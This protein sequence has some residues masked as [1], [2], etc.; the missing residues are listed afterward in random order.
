MKSF[1]K[2][3][4]LSVIGV[5]VFA[6]ALAFTLISTNI[7]RRMNEV[8]AQQLHV[9]SAEAD[10][11]HKTL[12]VA[13]LHADSLL[14]G[15]DLVHESRDGHVD[16]PRMRRGNVA[17]EA[18]T[19]VTKSPKGQNIQSNA[20]DASDRV[21]L[22]AMLNR[23]PLRSWSSL[24][25]RALYQAERLHH[26]EKQD[27]N[28]RIVKTVDDLDRLLQDR[29]ENPDL[30][31]GFLGIEGL[32]CLEGDFDNVGVMI[33][34]GFRMMSATHFFD[35]ELGGSAHGES[36]EGLSEFGRKVIEHLQDNSILV[37]LAHVSPAMID[38]I[39]EIATAP[40]VV[41]HTGVKGTCDS[42]RNLSDEHLKG[43]AKNGGVIAIGMW[44]EAVCGTD[45]HAS[46]D[47]MRYVTNL[48]GIDHVAIGSDYDGS[49][50]AP[51]DI[52]G[53][54]LITEALMEDGFTEEE[55]GKIMG[56]NI[57]RVLRETLPK[58]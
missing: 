34:A 15:R 52:T 56:G 22:L 17:L 45:I 50:T 38:D 26:F 46:V 58:K 57:V 28:F 27:D 19:V 40:V 47:A 43:I 8:R 25:E 35:N 33:D 11:L 23:W 49:I 21:T 54:P 44:E 6:V 51:F 12:I 14:F 16:F 36:H 31:G 55:I 39:L 41:S 5:T 9:A 37:D 3:H 2:R 18:F 13:D 29:E 53:F 24:K 30:I 20:A 48:V 4:G 1:L 10:A 42:P 32:H 7:D